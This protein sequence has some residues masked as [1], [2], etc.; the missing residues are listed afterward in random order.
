MCKLTRSKRRKDSWVDAERIYGQRIGWFSEETGHRVSG[1]SSDRVLGGCAGPECLSSSFTSF[2]RSERNVSYTQHHI[3]LH[4]CFV[5]AM[6]LGF[7][8]CTDLRPANLSQE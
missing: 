2:A 6:Y 1:Q 5:P 7:V 3:S 4:P 8:S